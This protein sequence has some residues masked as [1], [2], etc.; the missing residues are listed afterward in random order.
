MNFETNGMG[1]V[2]IESWLFKITFDNRF[3]EHF[4]NPSYKHLDLHTGQNLYF[5]FKDLNILLPST[6]LQTFVVT[7]VYLVLF[8]APTL[9]IPIVL[10]S[11]NLR[12]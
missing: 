9:N 7:N 1:Q 12:R 6:V 8:L 2:N 4:R 10:L 3:L 5:E 11:S